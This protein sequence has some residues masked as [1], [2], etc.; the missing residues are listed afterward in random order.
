MKFTVR[1]EKGTIERVQPNETPTVELELT[2]HEQIVYFELQRDFPAASRK[3]Y[4]WRW[5]AYIARQA[6]K[7]P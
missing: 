1:Q 2:D 7:L 4:D 5:T 3:T 6:P